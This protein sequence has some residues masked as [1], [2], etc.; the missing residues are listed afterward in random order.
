MCIWDAVDLGMSRDEIICVSVRIDTLR[1]EISRLS[2]AQ[3]ELR[4]LEK[5]LDI[6]L[7]L[8]EV[9]ASNESED[10]LMARV[11]SLLDSNAIRDYDAEELLAE[12]PQENIASIRSV[13]SRT[14]G[15]GRIVRTARGRYRTNKEPSG[16]LPV[17][18][19]EKE[20]LEL[21]A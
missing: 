5:Q 10:S 14:S 20:G 1:K 3:R 13:L 21:V 11:L 6:M 2:E 18:S 7:G 19:T 4:G 9:A 12:W 8:V 16:Q 17:E 15:T